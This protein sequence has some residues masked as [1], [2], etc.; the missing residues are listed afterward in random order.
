MPARADSLVLT[1]ADTGIGIAADQLDRLG[2]PFHQVD[3]SYTRQ[4]EGT[5]LGLSLVKGL[6][7]LHGG[8]VEMESTPDVG[9]RVTVT[10]PFA[11]SQ[12]DGTQSEQNTPLVPIAGIERH[13]EITR[14]EGNQDASSQYG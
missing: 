3:N 12:T 6:V 13:E 8:S 14:D 10:I 1:V 9:T 11:D 5:G 2:Q 7:G 4:C